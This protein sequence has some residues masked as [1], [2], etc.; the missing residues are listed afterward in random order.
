MRTHED[1]RNQGCA[2][3]VSPVLAPASWR[4]FRAGSALAPWWRSD[5]FSNQK[6]RLHCVKTFDSARGLLYKRVVTSIVLGNPVQG[7]ES[8]RQRPTL[9]RTA[10]RLTLNH[11]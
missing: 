3:A 5:S 9:A 7:S 10:A 8:I 2:R 6:R 11:Y 4:L 1:P